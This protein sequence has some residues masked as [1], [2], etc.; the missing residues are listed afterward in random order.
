MDDIEKALSDWK[1]SLCSEVDVGGL[2]TRNAVREE[3][4]ERAVSSD[5]DRRV[6]Y[7]T[8][9]AVAAVG[10]GVPRVRAMVIRTVHP[11]QPAPNS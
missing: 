5:G 4:N 1:Q 11:M 10:H 2:F 3:K 8:Y 6:S 9:R 7:K